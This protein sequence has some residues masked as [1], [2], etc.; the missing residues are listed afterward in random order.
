MTSNKDYLKILASYMNCENPQ[1]WDEFNSPYDHDWNWVMDAVDKI[2]SEGF[3]ICVNK[4]KDG[5]YNMYV[6]NG[7]PWMESG[8]PFEIVKFKMPTSRLEATSLAIKFFTLWSHEGRPSN[9][10]YNYI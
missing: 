6:V 2:E 10:Q 4:I 8:Q 9:K 3:T 7:S 1:A 5:E